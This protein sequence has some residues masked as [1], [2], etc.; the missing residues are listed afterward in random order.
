MKFGQIWRR[1]RGKRVEEKLVE[2]KRDGK[3][4]GEGG[5]HCRLDGD[6]MR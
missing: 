6:K 4:E 2:N 1:T 3:R 5:E